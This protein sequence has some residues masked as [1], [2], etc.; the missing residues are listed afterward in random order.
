MGQFF[1]DF[2]IFCFVW[3]SRCWVSSLDCLQSSEQKEH[4]RNMTCDY[5]GFSSLHT[6]LH[7]IKGEFGSLRHYFFQ[8]FKLDLTIVM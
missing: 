6:T 4:A 3:K 5:T 7:N 8:L 2:R 1:S